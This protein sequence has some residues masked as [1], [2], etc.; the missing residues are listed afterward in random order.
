M[1]SCHNRLRDV[2]L[3]SCQ[4]ACLSPHVEAESCLWHEGHST[5]PA[6]ILIPHWE[7]N[8]PAAFDLTITSTLNSSTLVEASV[9]DGYAALHGSQGAQA[10]FHRCQMCRAW[11]VLYPHC[12]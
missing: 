7:L 9:T 1:V 10:Q 6:D 2:L 12:S 8:K 4:Q 5:R 11:L 3:E